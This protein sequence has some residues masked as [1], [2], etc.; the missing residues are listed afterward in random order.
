MIY[1]VEVADDEPHLFEC[2][3]FKFE[4]LHQ[5]VSYLPK[6]TCDVRKV[7]IARGWRLTSNS[8]DSFTFTVPR[9]KVGQS[10]V[11]GLAPEWVRLASNGTNL[12]L[13]QIRF[14]F[15]LAHRAKMN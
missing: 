12:G 1:S 14:Q 7:E 15:V 3:P 10:E 8:V 5:A 4:G 11:S 2:A 9:V 6:Y 13:F